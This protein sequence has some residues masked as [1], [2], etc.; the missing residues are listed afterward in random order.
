M[1]IGHVPLVLLVQRGLDWWSLGFLAL[2]A[3]ML[4]GLALYFL[5]GTAVLRRTVRDYRLRL[6]LGMRGHASEAFIMATVC[7]GG[8]HLAALLSYQIYPFKALMVALSLLFFTYPV[9]FLVNTLWNL[10]SEVRGVNSGRLRIN[11]DFFANVPLRE[12]HAP[13]LGGYLPVTVLL[14]VY[15][16]CN[17]V[18]F[19]T[20]DACREACASYTRATGTPANLVVADDGLAPMLGGSLALATLQGASGRAA[21]RIGYYRRH[22]VAFVAR[23][24]GG[25]KGKF[26]KGSNLN[27]VHAL[28]AALRSGLG[29]GTLFSPGGAFAG[30]W[31][32]GEICV[33]DLI[34]LLDKDS[35]PAPGILAAT[36]PEF[37][38]DPGLAF[39]QHVSRAANADETFFSA[40]LGHFN[41]MV[42]RV[43][44]PNK[45]L[46]GLQV[47]LMGHNAF[48]RKSF[49]ELSGGWSEHRVSEDYAKS[50]DAYRMGWHGKYIAFE[51]MEFTEHVCSGFTEE[52]GKQLRY[53]YG[54]TEVV[55]GGGHRLPFAHYAD[56][57]VY[58][59]SYFNLAAALPTILLLLASHQIYYLFAGMLINAFIFLV[60]PIAHALL[61]KRSIGFSGCFDVVRYFLLNG[62]AF[63]G[64]TYSMLRGFC[65]YARDI[66]LDRYE[67]FGATS[68]DSVDPSFRAG[69]RALGAYYRSNAPVV[70]VSVLLAFGCVMVLRDIPPH[71]IR[72]LIVVFLLAHVAAPVL[73]TPQLYRFMV[74]ATR[75]ANSWGHRSLSPRRLL[76]GARAR[77]AAALCLVRGL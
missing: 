77:V 2:F 15:T 45:A 41:D 72:P 23:P 11:S 62:L 12:R 31:A 21:E 37:V 18:I 4:F 40:I 51:G 6:G 63:L 59:C 19:K 35:I 54:I 67:P 74:P 49:L 36:A 38:Q 58:Y 29:A 3:S 60:F 33:H 50:L 52:T 64:H 57:V 47:H 65:A 22:N 68:V 8:V 20:V 71:V 39:T 56:L 26:K 28:E 30:G 70:I 16:E 7:N 55:L 69:L 24:A 61:L 13:S 76:K 10:Q 73:L 14:P 34:L 46:Q 53:S 17:A 44:L 25:R 1:A 42:Y 32:E 48:I 75:K 43:A 27:Y 5:A 66:V 9:Y